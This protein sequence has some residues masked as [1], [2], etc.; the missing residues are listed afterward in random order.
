MVDIASMSTLRTVVARSQFL[1][2]NYFSVCPIVELSKC[3][4]VMVFND[5]LHTT[6]IIS[7]YCVHQIDSY[8]EAFLVCI[9]FILL[10]WNVQHWLESIANSVAQNILQGLIWVYDPYFNWSNKISHFK[11]FKGIFLLSWK[12]KLK[13]LK[14]WLWLNC[15][16]NMS[17]WIWSQ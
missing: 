10:K 16:I 8:F 15:L 1:R 11:G 2:E 9:Y 13:H 6:S 14:Y 7:F 5:V 4:V 3:D 17:S 12:F